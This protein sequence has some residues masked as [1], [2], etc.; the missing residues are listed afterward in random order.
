MGR[1]RGSL[2]PIPGSRFIVTKAS[3]YRKSLEGREMALTYTYL[4]P[5]VV[6]SVLIN[7]PTFGLENAARQAGAFTPILQMKKLQSTKI[8]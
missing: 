8:K 7:V 2:E 6:L 1:M 4:V 3:D 5:S